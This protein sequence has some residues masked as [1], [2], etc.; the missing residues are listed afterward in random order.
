MTIKDFID[1]EYRPHVEATLAASTVDGYS[2]LWRGYAHYFTDCELTL[3]VFEAQ[4]IL[5]QIALDNPHL[6]KSSLRHIKTFLGGVFSHA[7]RCGLTESNPWSGRAV[8]IPAA[9]DGKETYAYSPEEASTILLHLTGQA[10]LAMSIAFCAG[11]RKSEIRG[12]QPA[13]WCPETKTLSIRRAVW[14]NVVKTTKSKASKADVPVIGHLAD[15]LNTYIAQN[16][17]KRFLLETSSG[18]PTD[19]DNLA[20]G[21]IAPALSGTGVKF[22][23][24]HAARRG[25]AT[26]LHL[27]NVPD[28][29]IQA[30]LRHSNI[31]VTM[32]SYVKAIPT[33]TRNA[34]EAVN[35]GGKS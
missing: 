8:A 27:N 2:K 6:T 22:R 13:D 15:E 16:K 20:R 23:G 5:R 14:R 24:W 35:Y 19:L 10:H 30:L 12:L 7:Q 9:P 17:P 33:S 25:L 3:R 4:K 28:K 21:T 18:R 34:M 29:E 26:Y 32:N 31:S 11:L 1:Q